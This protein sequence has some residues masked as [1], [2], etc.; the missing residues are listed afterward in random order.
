MALRDEIIASGIDLSSRDPDVIAAEFSARRVM[1]V[2]TTI[3]IGTILD[4]LGPDAGAV[5]L[6]RLDSL[7]AS[8]PAIKWA[9]VLIDRGDLD[10]GLT[11]VRTQ[12]DT[13]ASQDVMSLEQAAALKAL[14]EKPNP[15]TE[16]EVR[17]ALFDPQ[18]G[19]W[20]GA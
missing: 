13:L 7:R 1:I 6:D 3:G 17:C 19:D 15:I 2:R 4:T 9:W 18:T 16:F 14:A 8:V 12:I 20:R 5:L 11:S 10:V